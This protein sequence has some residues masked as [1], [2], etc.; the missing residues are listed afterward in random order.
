M[1]DRQAEVL[2]IRASPRL[3]VFFPSQLDGAGGI[4]RIHLLNISRTG[5]LIY[6]SQP[7]EKGQKVS[8]GSGERAK[9]AIVAWVSGARAGVEFR[10]PFHEAELDAFIADQNAALAEAARTIG[11]LR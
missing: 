3:K 6:S 8:V 2:V 9:L 5:A 4:I 11:T 10:L 7:L 1:E